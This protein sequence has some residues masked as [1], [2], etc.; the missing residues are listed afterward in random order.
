MT[1]SRPPI[2][3]PALDR[4]VVGALLL[5]GLGLRIA[6]ARAPGTSFSDLAG[7]SRGITTWAFTIGA[8]MAA[9]A[10]TAL[11]LFKCG[12]RTAAGLA[13]AIGALDPLRVA[14]A[15][16]GPSCVAPAVLGACAL[17][18]ACGP[19]L[20]LRTLG[21]AGFVVLAAGFVAPVPLGGVPDPWPLAWSDDARVGAVCAGLNHFGWMAVVLAAFGL[22]RSP[23]GSRPIFA[24]VLAAG[25]W[26]LCPGWH[27]RLAAFVALS[28]A[29]VAGAALALESVAEKSACA[30]RVLFALV[31]LANAP[32]LVSDAGG[33]LRF[34]T[35]A[36]IAA[37]SD[38]D[39][40]DS[41]I[42][43]PTP[44]LFSE[45]GA[46]VVVLEKSELPAVD[47]T[48]GPARI[49][50]LPI[51]NERACD[52]SPEVLDAVERLTT[53]AFEH[54]MRRFDLYRLEL[55][56]YRLGAARR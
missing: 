51:L 35:S 4:R 24:F 46:R 6:V 40:R 52:V 29:L 14:A 32:T 47:V 17:A 15:G 20:L 48:K 8:E 34:P 28:P 38:D 3:S 31:V 43:A 54:R 49:V 11:L 10:I 2:G 13:L 53:P 1:A 42:V 56:V 16:G 45:T 41:E 30:A 7:G 19:G 36:A 27:D 26:A 39:R 50:I 21:A 37:L 9:L 12:R 44:A 23:L 25:A 55:R 33:G 18:L 5:A 22:V